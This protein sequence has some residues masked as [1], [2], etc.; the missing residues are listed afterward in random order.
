MTMWLPGMEKD[1]RK[2]DFSQWY[3]RPKDADWFWKW[4]VSSGMYER[5]IEP[6]A[7]T[8]N[9]ARAAAFGPKAPKTI[10]LIDADPDNELHMEMFA[11]DVAE[12]FGPDVTHQ[13]GDFT[14]LTPPAAPAYNLALMNPPYEDNQ[15]VTHI[16]EA[17]KYAGRVACLVRAS[18]LDG[19]DR[20]DHFW[21]KVRIVRGCRAGRLQFGGGC[22]PKGDYVALDLIQRAQHRTERH[23]LQGPEDMERWTWK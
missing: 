18:M 21:S 14:N 9:L 6:S 16:L 22:T 13:V 12:S 1:Q 10:H 2:L 11:L 15:D 3:T 20:T 8:C 23:S 5:V 17:F 19:Q 4:V 7:G